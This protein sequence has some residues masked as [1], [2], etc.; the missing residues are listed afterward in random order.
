MNGMDSEAIE[1]LKEIRT[2]LESLNKRFTERF[3]T[4]AEMDAWER[5]FRESLT[6]KPQAV[7][8]NQ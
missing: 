5:R 6:V 7:A 8:E 4:S 1:L 3:P 2:L